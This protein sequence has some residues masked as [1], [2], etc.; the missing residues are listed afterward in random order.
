VKRWLEAPKQVQ[1]IDT[2]MSFLQSQQYA[3]LV[4]SAMQNT[5]RVQ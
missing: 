5:R 1:Y 3:M 4:G 2:A